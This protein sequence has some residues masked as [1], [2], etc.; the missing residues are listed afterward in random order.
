[1]HV[2]L[3]RLKQLE[4]IGNLSPEESPDEALRLGA[5]LVRDWRFRNGQ[6]TRRARMVAREFKGNDSG[7]VD[8]FRFYN[9]LVIVKMMIALT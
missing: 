9:A 4:V 7:S 2:D 3:E 5:K 1:M 6:W 8:T